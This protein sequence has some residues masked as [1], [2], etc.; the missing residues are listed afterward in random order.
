MELLIQVEGRNAVEGPEHCLAEGRWGE[1][2][3][4][5]GGRDPPCPG[6]QMGFVPVSSSGLAESYSPGGIN[7]RTLSLRVL[8]AGGP[9]ECR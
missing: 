8:E 3:W 5:L 9:A 6:G 2:G 4:P 7:N 1:Q